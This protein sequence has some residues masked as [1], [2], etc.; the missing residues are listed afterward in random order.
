MANSETVLVEKALLDELLAIA[1][2]NQSAISEIQNDVVD[3]YNKLL[4]I[5]ESVNEAKTTICD[6]ANKL[7][8]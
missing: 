3:T 2:E 1:K 4:G 7:D 8:I 5:E 6:V